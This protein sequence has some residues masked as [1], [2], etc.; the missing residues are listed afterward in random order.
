MSNKTKKNSKYKLNEEERKRKYENRRKDI[1]NI[2]VPKKILD[3]YI[4]NLTEKE[5]I[6]YN[7]AKEHLESSFDLVKC[8][9]F[10]KWLKKNHN[11]IYTN[12]NG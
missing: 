1:E 5:M 2:S 7:I 9:G 10:Q 6:T 4:E 3:E 12:I 8:I 11:N